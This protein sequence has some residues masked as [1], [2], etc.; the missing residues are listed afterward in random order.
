[1]GEG[2]GSQEVIGPALLSN[3]RGHS[4]PSHSGDH[5]D[6]RGRRNCITGAFDEINNPSKGT[7]NYIVQAFTQTTGL[8]V[9]W[10]S[11]KGNERV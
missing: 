8:L 2:Q 11:Y 6:Y 7:L 1:M 4:R 5:A 3:G 9:K 10:G